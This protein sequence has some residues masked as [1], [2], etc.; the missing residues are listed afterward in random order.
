[1]VAENTFRPPWFHRNIMSE[2]MG[3]I[4]GAYDAKE[5]GFLPGGG[6]LHNCMTPHG[7]DA[8]A[9]ANATEADLQ[10]DRYADTLAFML[11]SRY[12][13]EPTRLALESDC[14]QRE[15]LDCWQG[16]TKQFDPGE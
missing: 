11:E 10:P 14:L 4:H 9:F 8:Q 6:S 15:Y 5:G 12:V 13:I 2:F 16:L 1:M 7:P 3:L